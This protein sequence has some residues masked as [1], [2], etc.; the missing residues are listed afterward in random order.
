[1]RSS[2]LTRVDI[3]LA[4]LFFLP[5]LLLQ[6]NQNIFITPA[7]AYLDPW[8]YTGYF[9]SLPHFLEVFP[10]AYYGTRL[11]W[12][13]PGFFFH[14]L[15]PP[16]WANHL[17]HLSFY[18]MI[19]FGTYFVFKLNLGRAAAWLAALSLGLSPGALRALGWDYMDGAGIAYTVL[20]ILC[21]E[22]S[23]TSKR[24]G[25]WLVLAGVFTACCVYI[26][27][28][29]LVLCPV[30]FIH[31]LLRRGEGGRQLWQAVLW[32]AIGV[33]L[34][35]YFLGTI[36]KMLGDRFLF[37]L[38]SFGHIQRSLAA[39]SPY[40]PSGAKWLLDAWWL[41]L[42]AV[43]FVIAVL[44]VLRNGS[45]LRRFR[46]DFALAAQ[47]DMILVFLGWA[48]LQLAGHPVASL[49]YYA[50]YLLPFSLFALV[51]GIGWERENGASGK[52]ALTLQWIAPF[53][54]LW[55][56]AVD[57]AALWKHAAWAKAPL[58]AVLGMSVLLAAGASFLKKPV[59]RIAVLMLCLSWAFLITQS[60]T[61]FF[62]D[63]ST[64][65]APSQVRYQTVVGIHRFLRANSPEK[66]PKFWYNSSGSIGR[67]IFLASAST[68]LCGYSI[69]SDRYPEFSLQA[70]GLIGEKQA[71]AVLLSE[72]D[73]L[74]DAYSALSSAGFSATLAAA[75][76]FELAGDR[77]ISVVVLEVRRS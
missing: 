28:F 70:Q 74:E 59:W 58:V 64:V 33:F 27:T 29:L 68:Y 34:A 23:V 5:I 7:G 55:P 37:F 41:V 61:F 44:H 49:N 57:S 66:P 18:Y 77:R 12:V 53:L 69:M 63:L 15:F 30:F 22:A 21:L 16:L 75:R 36:N 8:F 32:A 31:W 6:I 51:S 1:M 72:N 40:M 3:R 25:L 56:Y 47:I 4:G 39:P 54:W 65:A 67:D 60:K 45:P 9:L 43:A 35:T 2:F 62:A 11:P 38:S 46:A 52:T 48:A 50:S 24:S 13:L 14:S 73:R 10:G 20:T 26:N 42:P 76:D 19:V 17:L 71:V